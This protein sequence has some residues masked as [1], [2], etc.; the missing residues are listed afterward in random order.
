M[1]TTRLAI[2]E[3]GVSAMR[4]VHAAREA[5]S[6]GSTRFR[7]VAICDDNDRAGLFARSCDEIITLPA[8]TAP[9]DIHISPESF[10]EILVDAGIDVVWL[11]DPIAVARSALVPACA[12]AGIEV[13]DPSPETIAPR[14]DVTGERRRVDVTIIRDDKDLVA[15]T[16]TTVRRGDEEILVEAG[17]LGIDAATMEAIRTKAVG[18]LADTTR[19]ATI[20]V[21]F[22]AARPDSVEVVSRS[23]VNLTRGVIEMVAG[24]DIVR[25]LLDADHRANDA[26]MRSGT[27]RSPDPH[28]HA[29]GAMIR[30]QDPVRGFTPTHGILERL[31][32]PTGTG[33][34]VDTAHAEGDRIGPGDEIVMITTWD[35]D[36]NQAITRL[37]RALIDLMVVVSGGTTN[38]GFLIELLDRA[39][40][41]ERH[42]TTS[43]IVDQERT[44]H[45]LAKRHADTAL[46][47]AAVE[48][49]REMEDLD[50][51]R[52]YAWAR[53]G[54]PQ[55]DQHL[56]HV[57]ELRH[58]DSNYVFELFQLGP[59]YWRIAVD[60]STFEIEFEHSSRHER[61]LHTG[62]E[63][64]R[65]V[66][67]SQGADLLV[68]VDGIS[69]RITRDDTGLVR[70]PTPAVVVSITVAPGELVDEGDAV[71]VVETMKIE[72]ILRAPYAGRV[73]QVLSGT[74]MQVD[75]GSPLVELEPLRMPNG[76][77]PTQRL[78]FS[79]IAT[80]PAPRSHDQ[81]DGYRLAEWLLLGYDV[82]DSD[83]QAVA[84][85]L[86]SPDPPDAPDSDAVEPL[87]A[88]NAILRRFS[89]LRALRRPRDLNDDSDH[90]RGSN[91]YLHEFLRSFDT[92]AEGLPARY[93]AVLKR[94]VNEF[95]IP[96][97][98]RTPALEEAMYRAY[99][100]LQRE[101]P[102]RSLVLAILTRRLV[103]A[104][105]L[106]DSADPGL[107]ILLDLLIDTTQ[108]RD[109]VIADLARQVR[110]R[111]FDQPVLD[112]A[113]QNVYTAIEPHIAALA[114]PLPAAERARH[115]EAL[116][117]CPQHLAAV[118]STRIPGA[119]RAHRV[120]LTEAM[121]RRYYRTHELQPFRV[122][123][124]DGGAEQPLDLLT[125]SYLEDGVLR[126][127]AVMAV[128][129]ADI[130][131]SID[132]IGDHFENDTDGL[133]EIDLYVQGVEEV[134]LDDLARTVS[135]ALA[136]LGSGPT[137]TRMTLAITRPV[138][139]TVGPPV[140][141]LTFEPVDGAGMIENRTMR[142]MHPMLA[143]RL[144]F[145]RLANFTLERL[146]AAED[147]HLYHATAREN[148]RDERLF[149]LAEVRDLM[150]VHDADGTVI[151][152]PELELVLSRAV[153][154]IR[155]FQ[156]MR[157]PAKRLQWNRILLHVWPPVEL[158]PEEI[159]DVA[160]RVARGMG[161]L[162][163]E[164]TMVQGRLRDPF[165]GALHERVL[166]I[167][168]PVGSGVRIELSDPP[169]APLAPLDEYTRK[170]VRSRARG[171]IYPYEL[172]RVL[173]P[174]SPTA[175]LPAGDF[176]EYDLDESDTLVPVDR[177]AGRNEAGIVV[178]VVRN[179]TDRYPEGMARVALFG[180]PTRALGAISQ[181]ECRRI[182]G[183]L[184]LAARLGV[185][186]E[187]FA[188]SAGA[189]IAMDSGTENMDGVAIV[190]RRIIEFTQA[191]GE[192]NV[193]VT[194]I[195]VGA[196]PY[197]NAEA[198]MLMH[199]RG[200]L[201]MTPQSAMVLTGKQALEY[202]GGVSAEDNFG[203][204]G[205]ERI[206]GPNGQAQ[207]W[208]ADITS[209]C[210]T[211]LNHYEHAYVAPG[212]RFPRRAHT[213]DPTGRDISPFPHSLA[214]SDFGE[215]GDIFSPVANPDRK[216]SFD[217]RT[218]MRAC[219]DQDH[220]VS[221]R[222]PDMR[223]A[224]TVVV[225][226]AH[227][228]GW[229][230]TM[231]G[232]ESHILDRHGPVPAD[233]PH[234]WSAGT[235]FPQSAK[236]VA[237]AINAT[238]GNRPL[239]VL[240]NLSGFD[241]SPESMRL[242][243]L[244]YGAEIGRAIVNFDGPIVFCVVSR[245][246]GGAFVVFSRWLNDE[247]EA[248]AIEGSRASVIGGAPAAA[249]VF[250]QEV[251]TRTHADPRITALDTMIATVDEVDRDRLLA[252]REAL[253]ADVRAEKLGDLAAE[254]D[255]IHSVERALEVGSIDEII[256]PTRIRPFLIGAI[257][258]GIAK[259]LGQIDGS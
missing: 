44:H 129:P 228:G 79:G 152:L 65:I 102:A 125:S 106:V 42:T 21:T 184:D 153:E 179:F 17:A 9:D 196:Q 258:R 110:Y 119:N 109:P 224:A 47:A 253:I 211:L 43:W 75:S 138:G 143:K 6:R 204:G 221:E 82:P 149:A 173:T 59:T 219:S 248:V 252:E 164:M 208:A 154:G 37:K 201:V 29:V 190:L 132:V 56:G 254:F 246:H 86:R 116:V 8:P 142:G 93:V 128:D 202:S 251:D 187:W 255:A 223:G 112:A 242:L 33:I 122:E 114:E 70:S 163:I 120:A 200:I 180:D 24:V 134:V 162:G 58:R 150:P 182:M 247:L 238:S 55:V 169:T 222:W 23:P 144:D 7:I 235:L 13:L 167:S 104:D 22:V 108:V 194:G 30:A 225:W 12:N 39:E 191:G 212:E 137:V 57:V 206:M 237:R 136:D 220:L 157:Q 81:V 139:D 105:R 199:T 130:E 240:A 250:S 38:Q 35:T 161:G 83:I 170:V 231:I 176:V 205:Y 156:A 5:N 14:G 171:T 216:K 192:I 10:V 117:N 166:R 148:P 92:D 214:G 77:V 73:R 76:V 26:P 155:R 91:E 151:A 118:L 198:T 16:D 19:A 203:I 11:G 259:T 141:F 233:G 215:V 40:V 174:P 2:V 87:E 159:K 61:R 210:R 80:A 63:T 209:A 126:T 84:D 1:G 85:A 52:F 64:H 60:G 123:R 74:N 127:V 53:R 227:M 245:F 97:L 249:V 101:E 67:W 31:R 147:V 121:A 18:E 135:S 89:H 165:D 145:W 88:Q 185:P 95:A 183:A 99:R 98:E 90:G 34:R 243:Q 68:S 181:P 45:F 124:L 78:D 207:Y 46:I 48:I 140:D 111:Y 72:T 69:H 186:V 236:K 256:E 160:T 131:A 51:A 50:Q 36:R 234:Q 103:M 66:T 71:A 27:D 100:S 3:H 62:S 172:V 213:D 94:L 115:I 244:E 218:L 32:L 49:A 25:L 146:P 178:G 96:T 133:V 158:E 41:R 4:L 239:V 20:G 217:I 15:F 28:G 188:L 175:G 257:E 226:D 193:I 195:N 230:V 107:R 113:R 168:S 177:P 197:W 189:K 229:P 54:R 241:G 232:I